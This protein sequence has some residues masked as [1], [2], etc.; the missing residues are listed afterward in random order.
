M[1]T[2]EGL[3][4]GLLGAAGGA[5]LWLCVARVLRSIV[6]GLPVLNP[7]ILV[8]A[9]VIAVGMIVITSAVLAYRASRMDIREALQ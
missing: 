9:G 5:I 1:I 4:V 3:Q 6:F 7:L 8:S 2:L